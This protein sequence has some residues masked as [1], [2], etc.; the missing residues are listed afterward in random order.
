MT[1]VYFI[2]HAE[3]DNTNLDNMNRPLTEKGM[4]DRILVT[5]YLKDKGI[6][7]VLSSPYKRAVDTLSDFTC[8][9]GLNIEI[10]DGF[11]E[12]NEDDWT[13]DEQFYI[14][15][16]RQWEDFS[17]KSSSGES[18][19]EVQWRN[20][21]AL[22]DA[23]ERYNGKNIAVGTHG[24]ALSMIINYYDKTYDIDG[25]LAMVKKK[26]WAVRMDFEGTECVMI[27]KTD[28]L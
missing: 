13:G 10:I 21:A 12:Q 15:N 2:R 26:P 1:T 7:T 6:D 28:L 9:Y 23:L 27:K 16:R 3:A 8:R 25:F 18:L 22:N 14:Y 5:E 11:R 24:T 19:A 4:Q 20:I 17:L